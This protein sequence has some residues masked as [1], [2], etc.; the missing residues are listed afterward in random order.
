MSEQCPFCRNAVNDG[1]S[2]CGACNA[3][4]S[5]PARQDAGVALFNLVAIGTFLLFGPGLIYIGEYKFGLVTT[6]IGALIVWG[7]MKQS[8]RILWYRHR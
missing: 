5:S 7:L 6:A 1:A 8:S 4:K 3:F 2:V